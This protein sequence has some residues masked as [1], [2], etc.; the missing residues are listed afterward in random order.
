MSLSADLRPRCE[1]WSGGWVVRRTRAGRPE[2]LRH[3]AGY[4]T[5]NPLDALRS[6]R[7]WL[8]RLA[9][10]FL[11]SCCGEPA[12]RDHMDGCLQAARTGAA[13]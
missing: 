6:S 7:P 2:F 11:R 13:S 9:G 1:Y 12:I 8:S 10:G 4:W 3:Y 5:Q